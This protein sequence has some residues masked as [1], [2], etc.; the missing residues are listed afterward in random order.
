MS[1]TAGHWGALPLFGDD[2]LPPGLW[3]RHER[4]HPKDEQPEVLAACRSV[5]AET[6]LLQPTMRSGLPLRLKLTNAGAWGWWSDALGYRYVDKNPTT[7][8]PWPAIPPALEA[9]AVRI[10]DEAGFRDFKPDNLLLNVYGKDDS[11]GLHRDDTEDDHE[12][13]VVSLSLGATCTFRF[14]GRDKKDP[15]RDFELRSG[16][17]VVFGGPARLCFHAVKKIHPDTSGLLE[18]RMN[19]TFRRTGKRAP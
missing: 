14:G 3:I 15:L 6:G 18:G 4:L 9:L 17:A 11:L 12:S 16:A 2:P 5:I 8:R 19:L 1:K 7:G 10:A 13:P